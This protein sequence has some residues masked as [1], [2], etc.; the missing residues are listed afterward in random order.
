MTQERRWGIEWCWRISVFGSVSP[1]GGGLL[2]MTRSRGLV[3][4][5]TL[6]GSPRAARAPRTSP[7]SRWPQSVDADESAHGTRRPAY[8]VREK[9][10]GHTPRFE[11]L[12]A[13][14]CTSTASSSVRRYGVSRGVEE[15]VGLSETQYRVGVSLPNRILRFGIP[16]LAVCVA[17]S[18]S[19]RDR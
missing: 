1:E 17:M 15:G 3:E 2:S 16:T 5:A 10:R 14:I 8:S 18:G 4:S 9:N 13:F 12:S 6:L 19:P 7:T 11:G